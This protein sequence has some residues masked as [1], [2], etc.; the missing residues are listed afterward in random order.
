MNPLRRSVLGLLAAVVWVG[1]VHGQSLLSARGLGLPLI[2]VDARALALGG[3]G[4]GLVGGE[5]SVVDPAATARL[6]I[7]SVAFSTQSTWATYDDAGQPGDFSGTRFPFIGV[8]YPTGMGTVSL[9]FGGVLDQRWTTTASQLIDLDGAGRT[10]RVTDR[11]IS[12]GGV[13]SIRLGMA[14]PVGSSFAVGLQVGRNLG[15]VSRVLTRTFDSLGVVGTVPQFA[16]GGRWKYRGWTAAAGASADLGEILHLS[17]SYTWS[18][19]LDALP[20]EDTEGGEETFTMPGELRAGATAMLS[21]RLS[22]S[23][24]IHRASWSGADGDVASGGARDTFSFGGGIDWAGA[25]ILGKASSIRLGYRNTEMPF[26]NADTPDPVES[27][28]TAGLGLDLLTSGEALLARLDFA[29]ER[30]LRDAGSFEERFWRL[31]TS[32]RIS[33]F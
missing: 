2:S 28:F 9:A 5:L 10:G 24:G 31:S 12:D 25:R 20:D 17:A 23:F 13:S 1:P 15:D 21:P 26:T 27:A 7:P 6:R 32:V 30:G 18:S 29:L 16:A 4:I 11:F 19:G 22:A 33:G 8:G 14:R 3:M